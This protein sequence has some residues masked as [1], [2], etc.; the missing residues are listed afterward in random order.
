[1]KSTAKQ[2]ASARGVLAEVLGVVAVIAVGV[3][4]FVFTLWTLAGAP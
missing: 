3:G 4:W 2:P 1:M